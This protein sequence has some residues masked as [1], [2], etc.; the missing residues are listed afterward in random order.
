MDFHSSEVRTP[1]PNNPRACARLARISTS[2]RT[3]STPSDRFIFSK[4]GSLSSSNRPCH[5]FILVHHQPRSYRCRQ[6]EKLDETIGVM[7]IVAA[8]F[9]RCDVLPVEAEWRF[10]AL[11]GHRALVEAH[12]HG[13]GHDFLRFCE[14]RV[15]RFP[16]RSKPLAFIHHLRVSNGQNIFLITSLTVKNQGFQF[17]MSS[18]NQ[19]APRRLI[20]TPRFHPN[21]SILDAVGAANAI[22]ARNLIE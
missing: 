13:A 8:G 5:S 15:E 12:C 11:H 1:Q 19:S 18:C 4:T 10:A 6:T 3:A 14:E 9:K 17:T 16:Q 7:M 21:D 20:N 2:R 22:S